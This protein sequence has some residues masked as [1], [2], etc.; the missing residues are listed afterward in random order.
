M[1]NE[2]R[3]T[4]KNH[5]EEEVFRDAVRKFA[6]AEVAPRWKKANDD[7]EFPM[8]FY[9]AAAK[10]GY[11]GLTAPESVGGSELGTL[12]EAILMEE[13]SKINPNLTVSVLV[14]NVAG[15]LLYEF[16]SDVHRELAKKNIA[17]ECLLALA[18]SEPGAGNDIQG[19]TTQARR[20]GDDWILNGQKAWITLAGYSDVM[21]MLVQ[22]DPSK[23]RHGMQFFAVDRC[24]KGMKTVKMK[25]YV[26]KPSPTFEVYLQDVRVPESRRLNAGF[27]EIMGGFNRERIMV[28][29]RWLGH[30]QHA[31]EWGLEYAK[32]REQF[33][34][35]I[36]ANQSIAFDLAQCHV[37]V[38]ATRHL[39]YHA[40][41]L[42]DSGAPVKDI[43]MDISTAK[44][45]STQAVF[46]VTQKVLHIAG[47]WGLTEDL[48]AMQMAQDALIAPVTVGSYEIQL[49]A[50][51]K[52]MGLPCD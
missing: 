37:D 49:R 2:R 5:I 33:G 44:L 12:H 34:R 36:G 1:L 7:H 16:G 17:G 30:M 50:I 28:A 23:G 15:S 45:F 26:N 24:S 41:K 21:V 6:E 32:T 27:H 9:H 38:E 42:W 47:G 19:V 52:E 29:A 43:M 22:T 18:V 20:D 3:K 31:L 39:A 14:Q 35:P 40:A 10:A 4:S 13:C 11:I 48:P 25:T 8:A 51:A 46:R